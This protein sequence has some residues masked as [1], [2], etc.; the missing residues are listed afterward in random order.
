LTRNRL[1]P[2]ASFRVDNADAVG[3][4]LL[5]E[6]IWTIAME[7]VGRFFCVLALSTTLIPVAGAEAK[8]VPMAPVSK[9]ALDNACRYAGGRPY[10]TLDES[11]TYGC[12]GR[13]G[14]VICT[15]D[16]SCVGSVGDTTR[17]TGNSVGAIIGGPSSGEPVKIQPMDARIDPRVH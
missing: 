9:P 13:L 14:D 8:I 15:A 5:S 6:Q 1:Q 7:R 10:G 12:R 11:D 17:M 16:G 3:Q 4:N 2:A